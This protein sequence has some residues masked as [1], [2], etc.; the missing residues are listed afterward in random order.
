MVMGIFMCVFL[1]GALWYIAGVGEALVFRERMQEASD[2]VAFSTAVLE[3]RGM[4]ILVMLN[5]LMAAILMLL[6]AINVLIFVTVAFTILMTAIG[7]GL[8]AGIVTAWAAPPFFAAAEFAGNAYNDFEKPLH[9]EVKPLVGD[10]LEALHDAEHDIPTAVPAAAQ[11]ASEE[12]I[13]DYEPLLSAVD[14]AGLF[15]GGETPLA[16]VSLPVKD[17]TTHKLCLKS[18]D[19]LQ[20]ALGAVTGGVGSLVVGPIL[21]LADLVGASD[22]FCELGGNDGAPDMSKHLNSAGSD[23]CTSNPDITRTCQQASTDEQAASNLQNTCAGWAP[24]AQPPDP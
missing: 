8:A 1:V 24:P 17:G 13:R 12:I 6:V 9:D 20:G 18:F 5:L 4:N 7:T 22:I 10:A 19:A 2:A 11:L 14:I 3:A 16:A 23:Q 15:I 21:A